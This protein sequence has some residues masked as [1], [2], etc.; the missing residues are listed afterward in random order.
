MTT[1]RIRMAEDN[2]F[3]LDAYRFDSLDFLY[4]MAAHTSFRE[5]A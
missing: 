3:S 5:A 2:A 1:G 4:S